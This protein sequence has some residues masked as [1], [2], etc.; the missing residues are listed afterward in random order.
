MSEASDLL[1]EGFAE[2]IACTDSPT[3]TVGVGPAAITVPCVA[4]A[5]AT[6]ILLMPDGYWPGFLCAI[7]LLRTDAA[8]LGLVDRLAVI[9]TD[10]RGVR[11]RARVR[12]PINDDSTDACIGVTLKEDTGAVGKG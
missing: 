12:A 10:A 2:F 6:E 8:K 1:A 3:L 7:E 11:T 4:A 9:Y 5:G